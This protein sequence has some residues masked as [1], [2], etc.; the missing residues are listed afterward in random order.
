L[1]FD[2]Y[3]ERSAAARHD[4]TAVSALADGG[5]GDFT[6]ACS[7]VFL[8]GCGRPQPGKAWFS[9]LPLPSRLR[10]DLHHF[11]H[12]TE[13]RRGLLAASTRGGTRRRCLVAVALAVALAAVLLPA[14]AS[15]SPWKRI[16]H[17]K[18]ISVYVREL[19]GRAVPRFKAEMTVDIEPLQLL[20][21]LADVGRACE[22]NAA[23][24]H[25]NVIERRSDFDV[26]FHNRL[27]ATWP[28]SDRDAVLRTSARI[29]KGG[30]EIFASF[31]AIAN[32]SPKPADGVVRFPMLV[33]RYVISRK[34]G[35]AT[36][37]VY[38]IDTDP[39]GWVPTWFIRYAVKNVPLATLD[40]LRRQA[41]KTMDHYRPFR[42]R[43]SG[44]EAAKPTAAP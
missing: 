21:V 41:G 40:G 37:V 14:L 4:G 33:G 35:G 29:R 24:V 25:S 7:F 10:F 2:P 38:T 12:F 15:A 13:F 39:G 6:A 30:D 17:E 11:K 3:P 1:P 34:T 23:C 20:A 8:A 19:A 5:K 9:G 44:G 16:A 26:T 27:S 42:E 31:K 28:V 32:A 22:W 43:H 18:G 36:R